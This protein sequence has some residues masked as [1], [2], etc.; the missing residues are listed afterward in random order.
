M[1]IIPSGQTL[2]ARI[3]GIDLAEPLSDAEFRTI[4]RALGAHGVLCFPR[5]TLGTDQLAAFGQIGRAS[6]RERV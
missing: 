2:G 3:T 1:D 4:L 5:Q 6:C